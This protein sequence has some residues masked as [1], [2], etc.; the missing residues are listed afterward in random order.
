MSKE[1]FG[2]HNSKALNIFDEKNSYT[3]NIAHNIDSI[4]CGN[5]KF[6]RVGI[7]F[8]SRGKVPGRKDRYK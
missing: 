1:E 8:G 5:S 4:A 6:E 7:T 2:S 3:G